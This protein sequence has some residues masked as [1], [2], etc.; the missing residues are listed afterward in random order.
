[1]NRAN[2]YIS[3]AVILFYSCND[4]TSERRY[5]NRTEENFN[6]NIKSLEEQNNDN[7]RRSIS[8]LIMSKNGEIPYT[9]VEKISDSIISTS[10]KY[11]FDPILITTIIYKESEYNPFSVSPKGAVGLMQLIPRY[12]QDEKINIFDI[13]TNIDRG[14][15]ELS[16][17]RDKYGNYIDMLMAYLGGETLLKN[18]KKGDIPEETAILMNYYASMILLNYQILSARFRININTETELVF[19]N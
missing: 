7:L 18:Y 4:F 15:A 1:M 8:L 5:F 3:L 2:R 13:D 16:R 6:T 17:L 14:T 10:L 19:I 9:L 11:N 12:F